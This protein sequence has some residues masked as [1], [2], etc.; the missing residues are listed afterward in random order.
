MAGFVD[1]AGL[2]AALRAFAILHFGFAALA[3]PA[4]LVALLA[5]RCPGTA[6]I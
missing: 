2:G 4:A 5:V 3:L 1:I 6:A